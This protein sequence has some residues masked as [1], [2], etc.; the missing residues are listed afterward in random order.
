[1]KLRK[2]EQFKYILFLITI[3]VLA[4]EFSPFLVSH[5]IYGHSFSKKNLTREL[6]LQQK[7]IVVVDEKSKSDNKYLGDH[8]LH[9]YFGFVSVPKNNYNRFGFPGIEPIIR[10][11][12]DTINICL[13]GGSVAMYLYK[14]SK[15][16]LVEGL[17][18]SEHFKGKEINVVA[19]ALGGFKQPQQ[20]MALNYF[21]S[22]NAHYDIVINLDGFNEVA[23]PYSDNLP[24]NVFSNY[25]RH[26]NIYSRKRLDS[27]VQLLVSKQ[28]NIKEERSSLN[29]FFIEKH[30]HSSSFG[31]FLWSIL[32]NKK[33]H[34][35]LLIEEE[36]RAAIM[37]SESDYQS[38]GP[39]ESVKDTAQFFL[40]QMQ[41]WKK[42]S[43]LIGR[44]GQSEGFD[45]FHFLQPNQYYKNS[46]EFTEKELQVAFEQKNYPYKTAVHIGY[47]LL[48]NQRSYLIDKGINFFDLTLIFKNEK[49]TVYFDKCCHFNELGY[50]LITDNILQRIVNYYSKP[51]SNIN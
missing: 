29:N 16:K 38:T 34:S 19:F 39:L 44:I 7:S 1:M 42:S 49:R 37:Q 31:L 32:N 27:K 5:I 4:L 3:T 40:S 30:L 26:W 33:S 41:S 51:T 12:D 14:T 50:N 28:L 6:L 8:I 25:P 9:P 2:K 13:M 43:I 45:Y 20:L 36:L 35:L 10:K 22:L 21:L 48:V 46:K 15:I 47:P 17:Q 23:L 11:S 24:F 18:K